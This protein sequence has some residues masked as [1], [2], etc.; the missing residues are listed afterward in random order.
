LRID[1]NFYEGIVHVLPEHIAVL[2]SR[3]QIVA[4]NPAWDK[5]AAENG[6]ANLPEVSVGANY[7]EVCRRAIGNKDEHAAKALH[8][9][10]AVLS[11]RLTVFAMDYPCHSPHELRWFSMNVVSFNRAGEN[12]VVIAH[13]N[14]SARTLNAKE[15]SHR[16]KNLLNLVQAIALQTIKTNPQDFARRFSERL[17]SLA[18]TQDLLVHHASGQIS[19]PELISSQLGHFSQLVGDRIT[20]EGPFIL[21]N[22]RAA[23]ALGMAL[24]ELGTNAAKYGALASDSGHIWL[25]W[26]VEQGKGLFKMIWLERG[27]PIVHQPARRGF[28][29]S[30][31]SEAIELALNATVTLK[32]EAAGLSWRISCDAHNVLDL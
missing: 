14:V 17:Q 8:G 10:E 19:L 25:K 21:L 15:V 29:S 24:H 16:S 26:N 11:G 32:Y 5:F 13:S 20:I 7:I 28:G 4:T 3:G 22:S 2:D 31:V 30:L 12:G 23:Q 18:K 1:D 27:G 9:I 6:A